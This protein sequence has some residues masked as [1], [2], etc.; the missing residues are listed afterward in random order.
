MFNELNS[1]GGSHDFKVPCL[2]DKENG[3]GREAGTVGG[4]YIQYRLGPTREP[5]RLID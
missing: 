2:A 1:S 5:R 4:A 3:G